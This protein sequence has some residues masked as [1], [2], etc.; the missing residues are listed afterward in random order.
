MP[1]RMRNRPSARTIGS[2]SSAISAAT[3]NRISDVTRRRREHPAEQDEQ[4]QPDELD[5]ARNLDP[6]R[7]A[8]GRVHAFDRTTGP[9]E[10]P[11]R[12]PAWDWSFAEDGA[13]ALDRAGGLGRPAHGS[14]RAPATVTRLKPRRGS[15]T[16]LPMSPPQATGR[17][18]RHVPRRQQLRSQAAQ[19]R[20]PRCDRR[21]DRAFTVLVTA[22]GGGG[23]STAPLTPRERVAPA[24]GRAA[25]AAGDRAARHAA[26]PA[27]GQPD[28]RDRDRLLGRR[29]RRARARAGRLAG[30]R[31][32]AQAPGAQGRRRRLRLAALVP[33]PGRARPG[34]VGAR[35]R[36]RAAAPTS[37][38]R[39][40]ARSS[41]SA[42]S[43]STAASTAGGSTSSR[44]GRAVARRLGLAPAARPVARGRRDR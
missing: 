30:E 7:H 18:V 33:A 34:H 9:P 15:D 22:F 16:V 32:P 6:R 23:A 19:A 2:S 44:R 24:P 14:L 38:R 28:A 25:D 12:A 27:A 31:G 8:G 41:G 17:A 26:P 1:R 35:R 20:R 43:S 37:T 4:R 40:T 10:R 11:S 36:R 5:P 39:S 21:R 3:M 13:L 42:R 29:R